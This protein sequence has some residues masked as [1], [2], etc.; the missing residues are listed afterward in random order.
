MTHTTEHAHRA[1]G[2]LP[3]DG[4]SWI[5]RAPPTPLRPVVDAVVIP[6]LATVAPHPAASE[7]EDEDEYGPILPPWLRDR[8]AFLGTARKLYRRTRYK[9]CFHALRL[10]L[11]AVR[12]TRRAVIGLGRTIRTG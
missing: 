2:A 4:P 8:S 11:Y 1:S 9:T 6:D 3:R 12:W 5:P 7:D 10:P